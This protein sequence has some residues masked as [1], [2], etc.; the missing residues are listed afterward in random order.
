MIDG[1][2]KWD[3]RNTYLSIFN[4]GNYGM[5]SKINIENIYWE[6]KHTTVQER[7]D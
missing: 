5:V 4:K 2:K 7:G 3:M 6:L 1:Y